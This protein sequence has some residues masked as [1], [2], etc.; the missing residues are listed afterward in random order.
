MSAQSINQEDH[1][2]HVLVVLLGFLKPSW[3]SFYWRSVQNYQ[4]HMDSQTLECPVILPTVHSNTCPH[5]GLPACWG[6]H[7]A[8]SVEC[9]GRVS[10]RPHRLPWT[11]T[12]HSYPH[13]DVSKGGF[14]FSQ[15]GL[16]HGCP[17]DRLSSVPSPPLPAGVDPNS[18]HPHPFPR[19]SPLLRARE[20]PPREAAALQLLPMLG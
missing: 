16:S 13:Q 14:H 15:P 9:P 20:S 8:R 18:T 17:C 7:T 6:R 2:G 10:G 3:C 1:Y 4:G 5:K 12:P 19:A 11:I